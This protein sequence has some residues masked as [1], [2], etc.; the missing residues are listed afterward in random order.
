[1]PPALRRLAVYGGTFDPF[2]NG[3]LRMA[4]EVREGL[5]LPVLF[6][7][8]SARPPHKPHPP[9]TPAE[10]RLAMARAAVAGV[11]GIEVL[12]LELRREGPSWSLP[13]VLEIREAH[14]G[15]DVLF[16]IGADAFAEIATWHRHEELLSACDF[17]LLPRP[18][19]AREAAFPP[20]VLLEPEEDRCY[21]LPGRSYRLPGGRRVLCPVL[22]V[23]D[24]SSR[25]IREKVRRGR[26]VRGLVA[27]EVERYILEHG[28]YRE[29]EG[30]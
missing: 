14:P 18:G 16:V 4:I 28:L 25:A 30:G 27:P 9:V 17:L 1:V 7:V 13:T 15:A 24:I 29:G 26:S 12:D 6:L 21:S 3:H 20:G 10:H 8:P 2:H 19:T 11:G 5:G 23:L 22:P